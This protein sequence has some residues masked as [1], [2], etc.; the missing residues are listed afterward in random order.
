[1]KK[2]NQNQPSDDRL[3]IIFDANTSHSTDKV[4]EG[5]RGERWQGL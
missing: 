3:L 1:M 5:C 2:Q 4:V